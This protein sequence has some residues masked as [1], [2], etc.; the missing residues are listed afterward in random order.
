M[1]RPDRTSPGKELHL[2][3]VS[4]ADVST[5]LCQGLL[6][7]G[8]LRVQGG[9]VYLWRSKNQIGFHF[10]FQLFLIRAWHV[11][12]SPRE[13]LKIYMLKRHSRPA[14]LEW[15]GGAETILKTFQVSRTCIL[16]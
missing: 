4:G 11:S 5:L 8:R 1:G 9:P 13:L 16:G 14:E 7:Q 3:T 12:A 15:V 2:D 6:K 10:L